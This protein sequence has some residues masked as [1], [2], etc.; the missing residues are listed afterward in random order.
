MATM[1]SSTTHV[2]PASERRTCESGACL[3]PKPRPLAANSAPKI[4]QLGRHRIVDRFASST[5]IVRDVFA[6]LV[7]RDTLPCVFAAVGGPARALLSEPCGVPAG[8]ARSLS[9]ALEHGRHRASARRPA[10]EDERQSRADGHAD[11]RGG[12]QVVFVLMLAVGVQCAD[13]RGGRAGAP[14][15]PVRG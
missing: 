15:R 2:A 3:D 9:Y 4:L 6:D 13:G 12:Q 8:P 5:D 7:S 1:T 14:A 11:Q 10:A